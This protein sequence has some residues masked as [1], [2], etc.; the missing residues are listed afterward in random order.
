MGGCCEKR[1]GAGVTQ[2]ESKTAVQGNITS[3]EI[4]KLLE[5]T[6]KYFA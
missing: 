5:Y 1:S 6:S 2:L 3:D 4:P